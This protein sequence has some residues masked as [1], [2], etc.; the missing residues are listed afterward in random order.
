MA[1]LNE[2]TLH[3]YNSNVTIIGNI[4]VSS[5]THTG[6]DL[7]VIGTVALGAR[8]TNGYYCYYINGITEVP[9][10]GGST[11]ILGDNERLTVGGG[12]KYASFDVT[13]P[14]VAAT[15][16]SY[17]FPVR[18]RAWYNNSGSTYWDVT[19]YWT[20]TFS[21]SGSDPSGLSIVYNSSTW[22]SINATVSLEHWGGVA[23]RYLEAIMVTGSSEADFNTITADN[24]YLQPG[25][26][27]FTWAKQTTAYSETYDMRPD[28]YTNTFGSPLS[29]KGMRKYYLAVWAN[30]SADRS[31]PYLDTTI[32]YLPPA[33]SQ[34]SY[35]DP[36]TSGTKVFPVT[37]VGDTANNNTA[38]DQGNLTR[39]VRYRID[40]GAWTVVE[41][42]TNKAVD[43]VTSFNVS[44]PA[45]ST[46]TIEGYM[47][48]HGM[49]SEVST[50][51][52]T[53]TNAPVHLYGSVNGQAKEIKH[54]YGSVNG[55]RK[56]IT[57][58][59]ASVGGVAK[60]IFEES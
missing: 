30:N 5:A 7:R 39:Y 19:K 44:V 60:R 42:N 10:N 57:K 3:V 49:Q 56:K 28:N 6:T 12:D 55:Q 14:N 50:V 41:N 8:G 20:I 38:Y 24:W 22:N 35:S 47:T 46:A 58:L 16:T 53:N 4:N 34:F 27:R 54:L 32:R 25:K 43:T 36:G 13:I 2:Q 52:I 1:W 9:G 29:M 18:F 37:F 15:A 59:Y 51:T 48:Y 11:K 40:S 17:S 26:G 45:G 31:T 23:G 21:A 33:P